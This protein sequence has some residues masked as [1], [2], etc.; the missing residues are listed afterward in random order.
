[1]HFESIVVALDRFFIIVM[2]SMKARWLDILVVPAVSAGKQKKAMIFG[3]SLHLQ[4][5]V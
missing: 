2:S 1:M 5:V 4:I 3:A